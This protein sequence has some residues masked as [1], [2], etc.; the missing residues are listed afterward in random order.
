MRD[1]LI[2]FNILKDG[3]LVMKPCLY[4]READQLMSREEFTELLGDSP[5][6]N[7]PEIVENVEGFDD[8]YGYIRFDKLLVR[9]TGTESIWLD[10]VSKLEDGILTTNVE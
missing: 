3:I 8:V 7:K 9:T 5:A 1:L 6:Q 4:D 10:Y 2:E